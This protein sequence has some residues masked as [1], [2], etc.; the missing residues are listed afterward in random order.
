MF[1]VLVFRAERFTQAMISW[2]QEQ[3][4]ASTPTI[5]DEAFPFIGPR[6]VQAS[7]SRADARRVPKETTNTQRPSSPAAYPEGPSFDV[8][9]KADTRAETSRQEEG[10]G[11]GKEAER[12]EGSRKRRKIGALLRLDESVIVKK[13]RGRF[14]RTFFFVT[15]S[16]TLV[17]YPAFSI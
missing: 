8:V 5:F 14:F 6:Q 15:G 10:K 17:K 9:G 16:L 7:R 4:G 1:S 3:L 12:S 11:K 13:A 2:G